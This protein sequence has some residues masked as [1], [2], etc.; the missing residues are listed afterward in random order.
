MQRLVIF[1]NDTRV[2]KHALAASQLYAAT[3][4]TYI[5]GSVDGGEG[6]YIIDPKG[7]LIGEKNESGYIYGTLH[8]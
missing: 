8:L 2:W 6:S 5:V 4:R 1:H 3:L 7:K